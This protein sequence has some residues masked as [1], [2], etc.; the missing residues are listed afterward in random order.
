MRSR[1]DILNDV[2][3]RPAVDVLI[4]GG[5]INGIGV[6]RDLAA[7]GVGALLVDRGDFCSGSSAAPSRLIHGGLRYLET[8]EFALVRESVE[9]RNRLLAN[10]PHL[11]KPLPVWVP[12][13][14]WW[15]GLAR[16]PARFFGWT[17]TPG[18]KGVLVTAIGLWFYDAFGRRSGAV[19][20]HRLVGRDAM[21]AAMP[22][23]AG[24]IRLAAQY[25]DA[26]LLHP[27]RLAL[28]LVDDA[29][30]DCHE[31]RAL[32]YMAV[33]GSDGASVVLRDALDGSTLRVQPRL[34]VNAAGAW[35][36]RVGDRLGLRQRLVGG[37]RG[38]HLVLKAPMLARELGPCMIYFETADHRVCL[39]YG[40]GGDLVLLGTTDLP[41]D[42]PD[43]D[44]CTEAEIDYL[45][46]A[47]ADVLPRIAVTREQIVYSY[48]GVRP[49][50]AA[51]PGV[52]A[53]AISR[54]HAL[55]VAPA[56]AARPY[57]LIT[58]VGGK[59][60]TYRACAA[61]I[62]DVVLERLKRA[63]LR[64]TADLA[65]GSWAS[66]MPAGDA[67]LVDRLGARYGA[68]AP[69]VEREIARAGGAA[70]IADLPDYTVGE[71]R[72]L[73]RCQRVSRLD[74]IV[75]RRTLLAI[76]GRCTP[77]S[78]RAIAAT[79]APVLG[80]DAVRESEEVE[81]TLALLRRRRGVRMSA[82][83]TARIEPATP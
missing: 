56:D 31:A 37:T 66:S 18:A 77:A 19:P 8:G 58:L 17:R 27:E 28:E 25:Y 6:L 5:G 7:Q 68:A 30:H 34:V 51:Q 14:S 54:D 11:V 22:S 21:R 55:R 65:I 71:L 82:S 33:D 40:L 42:E 15:A 39:A 52:V 45:F 83:D 62:A 20:R 12:L 57:D 4:V 59:W 2:R 70:S 80:W 74:D 29:E 76:E 36:D 32:P 73:A 78:L 41:T 48:C 47:L 63:R 10:A 64:D 16:A 69:D 1:T 81:R 23:I 3:A 60:T 79:I 61:Q 72:Y 13:A 50:P 26:R 38:S 35:I 46:G 75:L 9:E 43:D 53:G 67:P 24:R 44:E 49:L